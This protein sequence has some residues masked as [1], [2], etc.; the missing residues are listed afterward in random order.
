M[1]H[2]KFVI[3]KVDPCNA[4]KEEN[5]Y[6]S[7]TLAKADPADKHEHLQGYQN[8]TIAWLSL[9]DRIK[10]QNQPNCKLEILPEI[11]MR[12]RCDCDSLTVDGY[13]SAI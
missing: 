8:S 3:Q 5:N 7:A 9:R 10:R 4:N 11:V 13:Q 6:K 2:R 12:L 1:A